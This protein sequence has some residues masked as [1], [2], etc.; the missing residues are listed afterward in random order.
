M[1]A[2]SKKKNEVRKLW[3]TADPTVQRNQNR[4]LY[5]KTQSSHGPY[6][7]MK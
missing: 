2:P 7:C 6:L 5:A 4:M 3:I 1:H